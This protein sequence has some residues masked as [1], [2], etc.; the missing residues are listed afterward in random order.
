M[1]ASDRF[2][3][4]LPELMDELASAQVPGYFDD[5]LRRTAGTRQRPAWSS[6]ERWLPMG[7]IARPLFVPRLPWR[8]LAIL[9]LLVLAIVAALLFAAGSSRR[10]PAPFG[11]A[12]NGSILYSTA[13]GDIVAVNP[14]TGASTAVIAGPD[15]DVA[16]L[17]SR[18]GTKFLFIRDGAAA[19]VLF[20]ANVDGSGVRKLSEGGFSPSDF[21]RSPFDWSPSGEQV[22]AVAAALPGTV[23]NMTILATD[24][25][26]PRTLELGLSVS[27]VSWRPNG[28]ELVFKGV[29]D[30]SYGLYVVN[31]D[32]SGLRA[33]APANDLEFGWREPILSP[34][35]TQ[36]AFAR[37]GGVTDNGIHVLGI[38]SGV[39]RLLAFDGSVDS[40]EYLPQFSPDGTQLAF[41]RYVSGGY[42]VVIAPVAGG[43]RAVPIGPLQPDTSADPFLS[44][45]PDGSMVL[46]TYPTDGKTWLLGTKGS[47]DRQAS[48]PGTEFQ[49]WQRLAP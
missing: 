2:E 13:A 42:Q 12:A 5:M 8:T 4:Q 48:W 43:G 14:Q 45:S 10:L 34:D 20:V 11:P 25:S 24:G 41:Q 29:K 47:G 16:P 28:R 35:G 32:G 39:D 15:K 23:R 1:T 37:W 46:V 3:R 7:V 49:S 36:I 30:A 6:L 44:F 21:D 26:A 31:A 17:L 40:D 18:D 33:I 9:A 19:D 22:A 27:D 38:D